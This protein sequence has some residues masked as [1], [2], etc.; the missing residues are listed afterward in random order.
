[1]SAILVEFI[2]SDYSGW[3]S[4]SAVANAVIALEH[5]AEH[6]S[7]IDSAQ[8]TASRLRSAAIV[9]NTSNLEYDCFMDDFG[10]PEALFEVSDV[11]DAQSTEI[12]ELRQQIDK[13]IREKAA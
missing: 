1:M 12:A 6:Q 10:G 3:D 13:L 5:Y 2:G 4:G 9:A 11:I 8:A 7:L